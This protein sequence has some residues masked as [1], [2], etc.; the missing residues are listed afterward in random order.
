MKTRIFIHGLESSSQGV[1]GRYFKE[2]FPDM[3]I[4][5]FTGSLEQR[6]E[7]LRKA[8][9]NKTN[10]VIVGS[11][12]GGLMAT[13]FAMEQKDKVSRLILLAP[14][15]NYL[16]VATEQPRRIDVP[17]WIYHGKKDDLIPLSD[18]KSVA[19]TIF[20]NLSFNTVDD[21]HYLYNTFVKIPWEKLL[22]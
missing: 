15:I 14:A 22:S 5:D 3:V 19:E 21:D 6:M 11:S 2:R 20:T 4:P 1:K 12:Y 16:D 17:V 10:I 9:K 13:L 18:V 7:T 8:L